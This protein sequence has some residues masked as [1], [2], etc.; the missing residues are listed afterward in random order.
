[1]LTKQQ[2]PE[3]VARIKETL[4]SIACIAAGLAQLYGWKLDE[5]SPKMQ[6]TLRKLARKTLYAVAGVLT[7]EKTT[8]AS[9]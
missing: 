5:T 3:E 4:P 9:A 2:N 8:A 1:M 7:D 6:Q